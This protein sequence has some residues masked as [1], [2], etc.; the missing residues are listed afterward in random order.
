M[1]GPIDLVV[2]R[3]YWMVGVRHDDFKPVIFSILPHP[4][5]VEHLQVGE[6]LSGSLNCD[7]S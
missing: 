2:T 4:V 7:S 5:A 1:S 6:F 3:D